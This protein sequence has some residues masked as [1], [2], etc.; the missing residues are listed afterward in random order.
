MNIPF[1]ENVP[2]FTPKWVMG[3]L[4][5][6]YRKWKG[7]PKQMLYSSVTSSMKQNRDKEG[8]IILSRS[9]LE[10]CLELMLASCPYIKLQLL[11]LKDKAIP[12]SCISITKEVQFFRNEKI[13]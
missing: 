1:S 7:V 8:H 3:I 6:K 9:N 12:E 11:H 5:N 4:W 13:I 2:T 10:S